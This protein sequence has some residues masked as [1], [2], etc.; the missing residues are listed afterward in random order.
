MIGARNRQSDG[1]VEAGPDFLQS[2]STTPL[3]GRTPAWIGSAWPTSRCAFPIRSQAARPEREDRPGG[4]DKARGVS[5]SAAAA[6]AATGGLPRKLGERRTSSPQRR[7]TVKPWRCNETVSRR[8][9]SEKS[10]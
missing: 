7:H 1:F 2:M 8:G 6:F 4:A 5:F 10:G 9:E 3:A